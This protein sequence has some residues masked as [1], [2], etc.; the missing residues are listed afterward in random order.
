MGEELERKE[1]KSGLREKLFSFF[2]TCVCVCVCV[3]MCVC[4]HVG[5][6]LCVGTEV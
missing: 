3:C 1:K 5:P 6:M 2:C 4:V